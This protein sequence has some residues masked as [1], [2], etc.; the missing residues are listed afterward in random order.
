[1]AKLTG[2]KTKIIP[3]KVEA[4]NIPMLNSSGCEVC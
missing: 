4:E 3:I 2:T 1:M